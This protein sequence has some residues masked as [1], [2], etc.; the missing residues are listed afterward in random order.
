MSG[1]WG[2]ARAIMGREFLRF[3]HQRER[4]LAA[5]VRPLVWPIVVL[6]LPPMLA[7]LAL[8]TQGIHN[9]RGLL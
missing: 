8:T 7:S 5:L 2:V 4:F 3:V 1:L 9:I 6:L